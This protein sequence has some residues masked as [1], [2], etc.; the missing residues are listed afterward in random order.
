[1]SAHSGLKIKASFVSVLGN[2]QALWLKM[3]CFEAAL[4]SINITRYDSS[5]YRFPN[6]IRFPVLS[7]R[8]KRLCQTC[9]QAYV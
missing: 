2:K 5:S 7:G 6:V 1:M 3:N 4:Y 9:F 8:V